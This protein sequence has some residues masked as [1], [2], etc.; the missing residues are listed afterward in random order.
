MRQNTAQVVSKL[1]AVA[2]FLWTGIAIADCQSDFARD[3]R[4]KLQAGPFKTIEARTPQTKLAD[5]HWVNTLQQGAVNF[6]SEVVPAR[7]AFRQTSDARFGTLYVGIGPRVWT[8]SMPYGEWE[9]LKADDAKEFSNATRNY[10]QADGLHDLSCSEGQDKGRT[11]RMYRYQVPG[12]GLT[13]TQTTVNA[14]FD[15]GTGLPLA[16]TSEGMGKANAFTAVGHFVFDQKIDIRPP[17]KDAGA[18]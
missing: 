2:C 6:V 11:V 9:A 16:M 7:Q 17:T 14:Q 8:K 15:A 5:G 12:D 4:V 1:I 18:R 13:S 3:N 10:L